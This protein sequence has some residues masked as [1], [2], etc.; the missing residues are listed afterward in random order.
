MRVGDIPRSGVAWAVAGIPLLV[1]VVQS[2]LA[3]FRTTAAE[4]GLG[5]LSRPI[6]SVE[7]FDVAAVVFWNSP[8]L[9]LVLF[10]L[11]AVAWTA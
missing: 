11:I 5:A 3:L 2:V 6:R 9:V 1:G 4:A 10:V 7:L 8:A